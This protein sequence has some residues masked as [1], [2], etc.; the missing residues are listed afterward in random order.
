MRSCAAATASRDPRT[1]PRSALWIRDV[2][3]P[4]ATQ[5][6]RSRPTGLQ[7][8]RCLDCNLA[9]SGSADD[10]RHRCPKLG[11]DCAGAGTAPVVIRVLRR[12]PA[13]SRPRRALVILLG[14]FAVHVIGGSPAQLSRRANTEVLSRV[15]AGS[16]GRGVNVC[17]DVAN[18]PALLASAK[19]RREK[20]LAMRSA[21]DELGAICH[22]HDVYAARRCAATVH[23]CLPAPALSPAPNR[24]GCSPTRV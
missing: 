17:E 24:M 5:E 13:A 21:L 16:V 9:R 7:A 14:T 6:S 19:A 23:A 20:G 10:Q 18:D 8:A 15:I 2:S 22:S 12:R 4:Q 1:S 3:Y 11:E